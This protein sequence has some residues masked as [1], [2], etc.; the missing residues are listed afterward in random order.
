MKRN[1][2]SSVTAAVILFI[3][4]SVLFTDTSY[5]QTQEIFWRDVAISGNWFEGAGPCAENGTNVS[6]W[7]YPHF[8]SNTSRNAPNC[9]GT[10]DLVFDNNHETTMNNSE[11]FFDLNRITFTVNATSPRIINGEG[12]DLR[13]VDSNTSIIRNLSNTVHTFNIPLALHNNLAELNPIEGNLIFN[14]NIFTNSNSIDVYGNNGNT[15]SLNGVVS[16]AGGIALK[17]NSI[18]EIGAA[19]TYTGGTAIENGIFRLLGGGDLSD[20]TNITISSGATFDLNDRSVTVRS[21]AETGSGNGG[22]VDLG[23][24]TL[25][26]AGGYSG[27]RFQNTITG[28]GSLVK[29]GSGTWVLYG[30]ND[31]TGTTTINGGTIRIDNANGLGTTD[32]L[33]TVNSG[34][35]LELN[36]GANYPAQNLIINGTGISDGGA[37]RKVATGTQQYAGNIT[38]NGDSRINVT[39]G[40]LDYRGELDLAGYTLY[41]GGNLNHF[42]GD[43]S[44]LIGATKTADDGAIFKDGSGFLLIRPNSNVTGSI[45]LTAGEI[46]T[47]ETI[48]AGG[49]FR[50]AAGTSLTSHTSTSRTIEKDLLILGVVTLG[51]SVGSRNGSLIITGDI[52]LN[53]GTRILTIPI[54]NTISGTIS[55]GGL[56]KAGSGTLTLN[57][58][59]TYTGTTTI[60]S[61]TLLITGTLADTD[62]RVAEGA[63]FDVQNS[64]SIA[65]LAEKGMGDGGTMSIAAGQA[66]T[67]TG[68]DKGTLFQNS[69]SG[70]GSLVVDASGNTNL[71]LYGIQSYTGATTISGGTLS[72]SVT[73][74]SSGI[75]VQD[76]GTFIVTEN[77][78]SLNDVIVESGGVLRIESGA[79]VTPGSITMQ[80][81][82]ILIN[83]GTINGSITFERDVA[84]AERWVAFSSP[85]AGSTFAGSGG[86]FQDMWTQGFPGAD[87]SGASPNIV[88]FDETL[89]AG[90][91]HERFIAPSAN[92]ISAG[93]GYFIFVY[94]RKERDDPGTTLNFPFTFSISGNEYDIDPSFDFSPTYTPGAGEG[95]NLFGNPT[96]AAL[97]WSAGGAAWTKVNLDDFAYIW[98][99][100]TEKYQVTFGG[101]TGPEIIEGITINDAISPFQAFWV[102]ANAANPQLEVTADAK[103]TNNE[104]STLFKNQDRPLIV[105]HMETEHN[106]IHTAFRFVD[107]GSESFTSSD[108]YFLTPMASSFAYMYS[109]FDDN[110]TMLKNLP[111]DLDA[112][113]SIPLEAGTYIN[114]QAYLGPATISM[115]AFEHIPTEW[116]IRLYD[117]ATGE[118]IDLAEAGSYKFELISGQME[119]IESFNDLQQANSPVFKQSNNNT[120][121]TLTIT[122]EQF[123]EVPEPELPEVV[124]LSQ[125]FPNPFNPTTIISYDLPQQNH[126]TLEVFDITGRYITTL[127]NE[128]VQPGSHQ[129]MFDAG[130]LSSGTYIY[131]LQAGNS[132]ISKRLTLIK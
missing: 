58:N 4:F 131:R 3:L 22:T 86:L 114:G 103:S 95:W 105:L 130:N 119:K 1:T 9:F 21:V 78:I 111:L 121:F 63:L 69:I 66:V 104:N 74:A 34:A 87:F 24:G 26:I 91:D 11:A 90:T 115:S 50:M 107:S 117:N 55:N 48:P 128:Q 65:S 7:F 57:G 76:G 32:G 12:I 36:A 83:D 77:T 67:I 124:K 125:N 52:D 13:V 5:A 118:T 122:N 102:K 28:T 42:M 94:E 100:V 41:L 54:N 25:T 96:G 23:S 116:S 80:S 75:T 43:G 18:V 98:N 53:N 47:T 106:D 72:T 68:E 92:Q 10:Y 120:R 30:D 84:A 60:D 35:A 129:V 123:V 110:P 61:G 99:P 108:A 113:L 27:D 31:F 6:Q 2:I 45:N 81:G 38:L 62:V 17:Q 49:L 29:N 8:G 93:K 39:G 37:L 40:T 14:N 71:S 132:V 16:G 15:L 89:S 20:E 112:E 109:V 82:S 70:D 33:V 44:S 73:M 64:I 85:V 79:E 127:V 97:D 51:S 56:T 59:N 19:M 88:C 46:R 126:V 101:D